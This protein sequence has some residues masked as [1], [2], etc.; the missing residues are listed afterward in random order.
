MAG[1]GM[2]SCGELER[3]F[4]SPLPN[5]LAISVLLTDWILPEFS[6]VST[7][8]WYRQAASKSSNSVFILAE[9]SGLAPGVWQRMASFFAKTF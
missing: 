2:Q 9:Y 7:G 1:C 3:Q 4:L 6:S 8:Y 5:M